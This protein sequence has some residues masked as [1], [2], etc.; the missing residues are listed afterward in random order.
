M[1]ASCA[2]AVY[3]TPDYSQT[4]IALISC[5]SSL[6]SIASMAVNLAILSLVLS[7]KNDIKKNDSGP[8][9]LQCKHGCK[10]ASE[11]GDIDE[12][13][14]GDDEE[15]EEDEGEDDDDNAEEDEDEDEEE[16]KE[17]KEDD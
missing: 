2:T 3:A 10:H 1:F 6:V 5:A 15:D 14:D 7:A 9:N 17:G 8:S 12:E 11:D 16:T 4:A 13:G